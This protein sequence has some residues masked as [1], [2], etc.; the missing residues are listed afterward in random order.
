MGERRSREIALGWEPRA[1]L[2]VQQNP[3]LTKL[4]FDLIS[5]VYSNRNC[6]LLAPIPMYVISDYRKIR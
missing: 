3:K 4:T 1:I 2:C 5:I 6:F